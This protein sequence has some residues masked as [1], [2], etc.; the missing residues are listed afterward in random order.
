MHDS[1]LETLMA[2]CYSLISVLEALRKAL[3]VASSK[4]YDRIVLEKG[5][6]VDVPGGYLSWQRSTCGVS[7][8]S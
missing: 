7:K 3:H 6:D 2:L 1:T 4:D 8:R 5:A